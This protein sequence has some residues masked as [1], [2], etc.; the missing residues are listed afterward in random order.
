MPE[1]MRAMVL[2]NLGPVE[3]SPLKL[4]EINK[5]Q[6]QKVISNYHDAHIIYQ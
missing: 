1:K 3:S 2:E 4:R 5:H 6:I